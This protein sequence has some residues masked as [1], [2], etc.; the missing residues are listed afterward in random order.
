MPI[1]ERW[2][3]SQSV[4]HGKPGPDVELVRIQVSVYVVSETKSPLPRQTD[5]R[6]R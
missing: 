6:G 2:G 4:Y 5:D 1:T 3:Q